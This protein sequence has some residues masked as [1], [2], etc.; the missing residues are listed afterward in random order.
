MTVAIP[1]IQFSVIV[2][3]MYDC[4]TEDSRRRALTIQQPMTAYE[5][6]CDMK[7]KIKMKREKYHAP[8]HACSKTDQSEDT[9][10]YHMI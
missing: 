5:A 1:S 8:Y 4:A 2:I 3:K 9:H 7:K 10:L 6:V